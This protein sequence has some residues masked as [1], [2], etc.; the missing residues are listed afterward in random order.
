MM[1]LDPIDHVL[2]ALP[3]LPRPLIARLVARAV[4][5]MDLDAGVLDLP[6]Y[7]RRHRKRPRRQCDPALGARRTSR[8][9]I[10]CRRRGQ[11]MVRH[12]AAP[13]CPAKED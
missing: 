1:D 6:T 4:T 5:E 10:A 9:M 8:R 3:S 12:H 11:T 13:C 2:S 7:M